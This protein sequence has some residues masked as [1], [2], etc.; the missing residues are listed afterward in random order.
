MRRLGGHDPVQRIQFHL[1]VIWNLC[2][3]KKTWARWYKTTVAYLLSTI[4]RILLGFATLRCGMLCV[5]PQKDAEIAH[6]ATPSKYWFSRCSVFFGGESAKWTPPNF[7]FQMFV[8]KLNYQHLV[9]SVFFWSLLIEITNLLVTT[10][11]TTI[12]HIIPSGFKHFYVFQSILLFRPPKW[13]QMS[14]F[15]GV[16]TWYHWMTQ[17]SIGRAALRLKSPQALST[18]ETAQE[19]LEAAGY[20]DSLAAGYFIQHGSAFVPWLAKWGCLYFEYLYLYIY[21]YVCV[22]VCVSRNLCIWYET[23]LW[24]CDN[25]CALHKLN[26]CHMSK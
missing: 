8:V 3:I 15:L 22:R 23:L 11:D 26:R 10:L 24:I 7:D 2:F 1:W 9:F 5:H 18:L 4:L 14:W 21:A 13:L 25:L 12:R 6:R 19:F 16:I 20:P 17:P